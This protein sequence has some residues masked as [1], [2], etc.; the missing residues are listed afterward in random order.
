MNYDLNIYSLT[1]QAGQ[2]QKEI[3]G[4]FAWSAPKRASRSRQEDILFL[5]ATFKGGKSF[6]EQNRKDLFDKLSSE[7]F[8]SSGSVTTA[9][10]MIIDTINLTF[11]EQNLKLIEDS[12]RISA[13]LLLGVIHYDILT[14][15]Q[16]GSTHGFLINS[17]GLTHFFDPEVGERGL[18]LSRL[19]KVRYFQEA[20]EASSYLIL[21]PTPP[22][23]WQSEQLVRNDTP[24]IELLWR[25]LHHQ[26]PKDQVAGLIQVSAGNGN[27]RVVTPKD[28]DIEKPESVDLPSEVL[29]ND[30]D[31]VPELEEGFSPMTEEEG[32]VVQS[33]LLLENESVKTIHMNGDNTHEEIIYRESTIEDDLF[34]PAE[35]PFETEEKEVQKEIEEAPAPNP[36]IKEEVE[37]APVL[38]EEGVQ[39]ELEEEKEKKH[40][41]TGEEIRLSGLKS[42]SKVLGWLRTSGEKVGGIFKGIR[43]APIDRHTESLN[44]GTLAI[45]AVIV[46]LLVVALAASVYQ[47]RGKERQYQYFLE[48]GKAAVNNALLFTN[49]VDQ[50]NVWNDAVSYANEANSIHNSEEA[51]ELLRQ[52]SA[53]LDKLDGAVRLVYQSLFTAGDY[54]SLNISRIISYAT[55]LYLLDS[56]TGKVV[57]FNQANRGYQMNPN[58]ACAAG[59]YNDV[60]VDNLVDMVFV[61]PSNKYRAPILAIDM[62]GTLLY[63]SNG[64][65]PVALSLTAPE[66]GFGR[67]KAAAIHE[68]SGTLYLLDPTANEVWI[69]QGFGAE[70]TNAPFAYYED[71]PHD[72]SSAVDFDTNGEEMYVLYEDG[73]LSRCLSSGI[74]TIGLKCTE[75]EIYKDARAGIEGFDLSGTKFTQISYSGPLDPSLYLLSPDDTA[76]YQFS[77]LLNL[78]R[79][80]RSDYDQQTLS[81]R[82]PS[83][84]SITNDRNAFIAFGNQL[85]QAIIP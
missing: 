68:G 69:Y 56:S 29:L 72:L 83:A 59:T 38:K 81:T 73:H 53:G 2:L 49:P 5:M 7:F 11:L 12:D 62:N 9:M 15:T 42:M 78:N 1:Y 65:T 52:A 39:P 26:M 79:I 50:R 37:V 14:V 77:I 23:S 4:L 30:Q 17:K 13:S 21:S 35:F 20:M 44:K 66:S 51:R 43:K 3:P 24:S 71:F 48:M 46:P 84:F 60:S 16:C 19:P 31:L 40:K 6:S 34:D 80:Y 36:I 85:Y 45:I 74:S 75:P 58:F 41:V 67:I 28:Q 27:I 55:D 82:A 47:A 64:R 32:E 57:Q 18:G 25:R 10:R 70:F 22:Q 63:C 76:I 33:S 8:K 61:S 54:P